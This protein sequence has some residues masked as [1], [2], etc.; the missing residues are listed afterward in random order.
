MGKIKCTVRERQ[1]G[2]GNER[3]HW[4]EGERERGKEEG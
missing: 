3:I 1:G 2:D 4:R